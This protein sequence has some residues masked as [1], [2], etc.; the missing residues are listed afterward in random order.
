MSKTKYQDIYPT[1]PLVSSEE[2]KRTSVADIF[3]L[4]YFEAEP[5]TM[6]T[7]TFDQH[8]ILINLNPNPHRVENFRAGVH[9][10]FIYNQFE[11]VLTPAGIESGWVWHEKSK[12]IVITLD[13]K[14]LEEFSS[15]ELGVILSNEHLE[16][17]PQFKDEDICRASEFVF[18]AL[19]AKSLGYEVI[20]ESL[21]RVFLVKL[22]QKYG[23]KQIENYDEKKGFTSTKYK[24]VIEFVKSNFHKNIS[25]EDL[26]SSA[27]LS[28]H[29]FSR[30]FKETIGKTPMQFVQEHRIEEAKSMLKDPNLPLI[31]IAH[32]CGFADQAHFSRIFKKIT[33]NTPKSFRNS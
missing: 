33:G 30:L 28:P 24:N 13:P 1:E 5:G 25:L 19:E 6:P 32:R 8:H 29:H 12:V 3:T 11:I 20:Y 16:D 4:E 26:A 7:Q 22:I 31:D 14:K 27:G 21:A 10:D 18:Q 17:I 15:K 23:K 2:I 9:R